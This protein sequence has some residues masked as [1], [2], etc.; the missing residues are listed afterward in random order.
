MA[1]NTSVQDAGLGVKVVKVASGTG[2][3]KPKYLPDSFSFI[4]DSNEPE[5]PKRI[6]GSCKC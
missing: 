2:E 4:S 5:E 1:K 6:E 3:E